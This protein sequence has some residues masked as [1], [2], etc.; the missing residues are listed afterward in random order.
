MTKANNAAVSVV[1]IIMIMLSATLGLVVAGETQ[2]KGLMKAT[3]SEK[4]EG[5]K[6]GQ[7][8]DLIFAV[9]PEETAAFDKKTDGENSDRLF[10]DYIMPF[11]FKS[12]GK[13]LTVTEK[14][15]SFI[16]ILTENVVLIE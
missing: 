11:P 1:L 5:S 15:V 12:M 3:A 9:M 16:P 8:S 14:I 6:L 10:Y 4:S 2:I 7:P 13:G